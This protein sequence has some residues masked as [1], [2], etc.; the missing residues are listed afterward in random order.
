MATRNFIGVFRKAAW[1]NEAEVDEF[2]RA[3]ADIGEGNLR[4]AFNVIVREGSK[5]PRHQL[6]HMER[7]ALAL[8]EGRGEPDICSHLID[9]ARGAEE[10][11]R[12]YLSEVLVRLN[13]TA[14]HPRLFPYLNHKDDRVRAMAKRVLAEV[15]GKTVFR[16]ASE[17]ADERWFSRM[18]VID[19]VV[20][21]SGH[22]S[23]PVLRTMFPHCTREE[24]VR[25]V[26][27]L[28]DDNYMKASTREACDALQSLLVDE[29][30]MVRG[31][32]CAGLG[33]LGDAAVIPGLSPMVWDDNQW[34]AKAAVVAL[35]QFDDPQ[36]VELLG[37]VARVD[38]VN[39]QTACVD[40]LIAVGTDTVV[41]TLVNLLESSNLVLRNKA[42]EGISALGKSG[43]VNLARMLVL[44][45]NSPDVNVRRAVI[46]IINDVG[47]RDG[48]IWKRLV[49]HLRDEDWWV[50]ERA[51][52]VL[53]NISGNKITEHV[54]ELLE[55][56][57]DIVRRYAVEVLIRLKDPRSIGPLAQ[58]AKE[59]TDWWVQERAIEALGD[60][61]DPRATPVV[62]N[63]LR[64]KELHWVCVPA[65]GKLTDPRAVPYLG[66][67]L[68]STKDDFRLAILDA[69]DAI[70]CPEIIEEVKK[71]AD[72]PDKEVRTR[73]VRILGKMQVELD[74]S[75]VEQ[76]AASSLSYLDTLLEDA[77]NQGAT[78]LYILAGAPPTM[79][80]I[81][82]VR[83]LDDRV[84]DA[85]Q[86]RELLMAILSDKKR[87]EFEAAKDVDT[88]Y[89]S[90]N[91]HYRFR[92][93]IYKQ[94]TGINGVFRVISDEVLPFEELNL[95]DNVLDFTEWDSGLVIIAG[96]SNSGKST[97]LTTLI[98][99]INRNQAKHI[100]ALEDP[101]EYI[102]DKGFGCL[103]NQRE[104]GTHTVDYNAALRSVLRE[105]PDV[106]LVGEMRDLQTMS[107]AVTAAETGHLVFGTLH[108]ISAAATIDRILD[109]FP[110]HQQP[111]VRVMISESLRGV[112]C[113]QLLLRAD[114]EG[115]T[116]A[117][118]LMIN[119]HA[120]ANMIR[121]GK[122]HQIEGAITTSYE[123]GMRLM[124]REMLQLAN[125]GVITPEEAYAKATDRKLFAHFFEEE[126]DDGDGESGRPSIRQGR[127]SRD[128]E[129]V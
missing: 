101:I 58:A 116:L 52:E 111:Q 41:P 109:A 112:L 2:V 68:T 128:S 42:T 16:L 38:N 22:Y 102:H 119:N 8:A 1:R 30:P 17:S 104:V 78:D 34:V 40:A 43:K 98:D 121:L 20:A 23:I 47:D 79:K 55:D 114:G 76:Q 56:D 21:I 19:V 81:G 124:D 127:L 65:L 36:S 13:D 123:K 11:G 96:P 6:S 61:G 80:I 46:E 110:P 37:E 86:T 25:I 51:T 83:P 106:I 89:E 72:D 32:A 88:S 90:Q 15:G 75:R 129:E 70:G 4:Q 71:V 91:E 9:L 95:P 60:L 113:Q 24:R 50:R 7:V 54:V 126:D 115:R 105:D 3:N 87:A 99:H 35:G 18:E 107:F 85:D 92:V 64:D 117:L 49:R 84:L 26:Q 12:R 31:K 45:M 93:N 5:Y 120:I 122:I 57:S 73:A 74:A 77:K 63:L 125:Q 94:H 10:R 82:R 66:H 69:L 14:W 59:D 33:K 118:E 103:V 44:M 27:H 48:T 67:L 53:V 97:T 39:I 108:T 62:V 28:S 100:I 29:D